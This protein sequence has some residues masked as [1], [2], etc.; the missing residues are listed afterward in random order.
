MQTSP[1]SIT[2]G[3]NE[4]FVRF[5]SD[6]SRQYKGFKASYTTKLSSKHLPQ[7]YVLYVQCENKYL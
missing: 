4:V 2:S 3:G 7:T 6:G 5:E 1:I